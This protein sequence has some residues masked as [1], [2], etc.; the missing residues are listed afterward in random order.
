[1]DL[2]LK[3]NNSLSDRKES[4]LHIKNLQKKVK[5]TDELLEYYTKE[6]GPIKDISKKSFVSSINEENRKSVSS[7]E[8]ESI[9][10]KPKKLKKETI[11]QSVIK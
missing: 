1:M 6:I 4:E 9:I 8:E 5:I 2:Q 10:E 11:I 3:L 7:D